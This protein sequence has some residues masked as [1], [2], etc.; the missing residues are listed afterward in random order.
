MENNTPLKKLVPTKT[1]AK[2][3]V[4]TTLIYFLI[5]FPLSI[6]SALTWTIDAAPSLKEFYSLPLSLISGILLL[7]WTY[8]TNKN[9][10]AAG[11]ANM[12]FSPK[13][14][15]ILS[16]VPVLNYFVIQELW[17]TSL[18]PSQWKNERGSLRLKWS[19]SIGILSILVFSFCI[20]ILVILSMKSPESSNAIFNQWRMI[21]EIFA[22]VTAYTA[23]LLELSVILPI[24]SRQEA[25]RLA[26][27]NTPAS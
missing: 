5:D 20:I 6:Y 21:L 9:S 13:W 26:Q 16:M 4:I 19:L 3:A 22:L 10:H 27:E 7:I 8:K 24:S 1:L 25:Y 23:A 12:T 14:A 2:A 11:A 18:N 17:K 15:C